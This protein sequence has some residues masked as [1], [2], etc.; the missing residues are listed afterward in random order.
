MFKNVTKI[1]GQKLYYIRFVMDQMYETATS[2]FQFF[3]EC[4]KKMQEHDSSLTK[5]EALQKL[6]DFANNPPGSPASKCVVEAVD[7]IADM[8]DNISNVIPV[9]PDD[10]FVSSE[11][12]NLDTSDNNSSGTE[13]E[14]NDIDTDDIADLLEMNKQFREEELA[15]AARLSE[16]QNNL[17]IFQTWMAENK[18]TP[19]L[20]KR[21]CHTFDL[22]YRCDLYQNID[23]YFTNQDV[24]TDDV[25]FDWKTLI[26][27]IISIN[28]KYKLCLDE[29]GARLD[30]DTKETNL[31]VTPKKHIFQCYI[32]DIP[33]CYFKEN[34]ND[35]YIS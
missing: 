11:S 20:Y 17:S 4:I 31:K 9:T 25:L 22:Q 14:L 21:F 6:F 35:Y 16:I 18:Q 8:N 12:D 5:E 1:Y 10:E 26:Y 33:L 3:E 2:T 7:S 13:C 30:F 23:E 19:N 34:G 29:Y 27:D 32:D 15:K 24:V 28:R